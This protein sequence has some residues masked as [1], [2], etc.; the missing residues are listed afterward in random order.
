MDYLKIKVQKTIKNYNR[1]QELANILKDSKDEN[2]VAES[3]NEMCS[4]L[5]VDPKMD[6][7]FIESKAIGLEKIAFESRRFLALESIA[8]SLEQ[9]A[10]PNGKPE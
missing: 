9:L 7:D 3:Y 10:F 2:I 4:I 5:D 6:N 1:V 8:E